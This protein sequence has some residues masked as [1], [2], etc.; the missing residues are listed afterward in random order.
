M[1]DWILINKED[2]SI[3]VLM[4]WIALVMI[5]WRLAMMWR[6]WTFYRR[7]KK[8]MSYL[9]GFGSWV[10]KSFLQTKSP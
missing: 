5:D 10:F 7:H 2:A 3:G 8:K 1:D 4:W 6:A 9:A